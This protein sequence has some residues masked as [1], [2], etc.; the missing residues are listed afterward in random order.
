LSV[1]FIFP[2]N[3]IFLDIPGDA[4]SNTIGMNATEP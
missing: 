4:L 2:E 1:F 3:R